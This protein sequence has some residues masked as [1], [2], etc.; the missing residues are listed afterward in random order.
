LG[1]INVYIGNNR[2]V[3]DLPLFAGQTISAINNINV[4]TTSTVNQNDARVL[5]FR[6]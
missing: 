5:G 2:V 3:K 4:P 1:L 6:L